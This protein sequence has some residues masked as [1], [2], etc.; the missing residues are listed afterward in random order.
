MEAGLKFEDVASCGSF[1]VFTIRVLFVVE[2][3]VDP[4]APSLPLKQ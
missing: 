2:S 1:V 3:S 4:E